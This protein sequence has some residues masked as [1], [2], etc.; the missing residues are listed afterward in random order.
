MN[1]NKEEK[2]KKTKLY[3]YLILFIF[4]IGSILTYHF[5]SEKNKK[6]EIE[7]KLNSVSPTI[8][9]T[10]GSSYFTTIDN[11]SVPNQFKGVT[12]KEEENKL[13]L[14]NNNGEEYFYSAKTLLDNEDKSLFLKNNVQLYA[15]YIQELVKV[16]DIKNPDNYIQ[17]DEFY[18]SQYSFYSISFYEDGYYKYLI[19]NVYEDK[20][21]SYHYLKINPDNTEFFQGKT[22]LTIDDHINFLTSMFKKFKR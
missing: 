16:H 5:V 22:D 1:L 19:F 11:V 18:N 3:I 10:D 13:Y 2:N 6:D 8:I 20:Y 9:K 14:K 12:P 15:K 7:A 17:T 21:L 4:A